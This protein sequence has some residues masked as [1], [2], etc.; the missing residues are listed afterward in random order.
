MGFAVGNRQSAP[1]RHNGPKSDEGWRRQRLVGAVEEQGA[2]RKSIVQ[3]ITQKG[4]DLFKRIIAPV[5]L[6]GGS[7]CHPCPL[8]DYT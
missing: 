3:Q 5:Q 8:K 2:Q 1:G 7:H 4:T 6:Q